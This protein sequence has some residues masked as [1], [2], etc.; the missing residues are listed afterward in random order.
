MIWRIY[1][2]LSLKSQVVPITIESSD[3]YCVLDLSEVSPLWIKWRVEV[4]DI[5]IIAWDEVI[6]WNDMNFDLSTKQIFRSLEFVIPSNVKYFASKKWTKL[7]IIDNK[8]MLAK[9]NVQ[10]LIFFKSLQN[11]KSKW[12]NF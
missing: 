1:E 11:A 4:W 12:Y 7:Y 3:T 9:M 5:R 6:S 10:N 8:T 2:K